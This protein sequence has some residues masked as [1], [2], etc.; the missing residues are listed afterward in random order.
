MLTVGKYIY[1]VYYNGDKQFKFY[2][3]TKMNKEECIQHMATYLFGVVIQ[4]DSVDEYTL[5]N[6]M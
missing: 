5:T 3:A 1:F 6:Q 2:S 4:I